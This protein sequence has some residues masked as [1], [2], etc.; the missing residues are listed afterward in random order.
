MKRKRARQLQ[1]T[2]VTETIVCVPKDNEQE[3]VSALAEL[4][5]AAAKERDDVERRQSHEHQDHG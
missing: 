5:L 1:L 2:F 3:L 4:L